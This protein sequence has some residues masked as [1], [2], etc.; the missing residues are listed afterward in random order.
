MGLIPI[1]SVPVLYEMALTHE[2]G[3]AI[4]S[5]GALMCRSGDKTGRSPKDKRVVKE[6]E[7]EAD[8]WWGRVNIPMEERSFLINRERAIDY[9]NLQQRLFVVDGYA[10]W[11]SKYRMKSKSPFLRELPP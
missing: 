11:N 9:L 6:P 5:S 8:V 7:S 10:G 4:S 2:K 1:F 3:S